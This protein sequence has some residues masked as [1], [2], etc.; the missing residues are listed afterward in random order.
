MKTNKGFTLTEVLIAAVLSSIILL[1][2]ASAITGGM[3]SYQR[4]AHEYRKYAPLRRMSYLL[5]R[6]LWNS[7]SYSGFAPVF[8]NKKMEFITHAQSLSA[9]T[10]EEGLLKVKYFLRGRNVIREEAVLGEEMKKD[11]SGE[12]ILIRN[13]GSFRLGYPYRQAGEDVI[14][15]LPLFESAAGEMPSAI[16]VIVRCEIDEV[17][18]EQSGVIEVPQGRTGIV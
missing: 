6:D 16:E 12:R 1:V 14:E 5:K 8:E 4:A 18:I 10:G 15:F 2:L 11:K 7:V 9:G 17:D 3:R 13:A